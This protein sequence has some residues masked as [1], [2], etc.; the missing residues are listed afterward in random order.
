MKLYKKHKLI[1]IRINDFMNARI[2]RVGEHLQLDRSDLIRMFVNNALRYWEKEL[3]KNNLKDEAHDPYRNGYTN[4]DLEYIANK[5]IKI[6]L[7]Q[8]ELT[9]KA[10]SEK[11]SPKLK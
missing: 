2:D 8:K 3:V 9:Q 1:A 7:A 6:Q 10:S 5:E 4:Q 11:K